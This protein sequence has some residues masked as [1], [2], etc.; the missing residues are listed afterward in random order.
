[1]AGFIDEFLESYGP[2]VTKQMSSNFNVDQATVQKLIPQLAPLI[3]AGLK[4]Q[5]DTRGGDERVDHIL[6]K[7][8]D[9]SVLNN[10]KD[11]VSSKARAKDVDPNLG[12]LLGDAGGV[13]AAQALAKKMNIDPSTIMKMIPALAP[14]LLGALTKKRDTGGK[15]ISGVGAL[16]DA[17]GDGSILDDVAG[18]LLKSGSST[19][20]GSG[21]LLGSIIGGITR[22]K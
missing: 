15:G 14:L 16:L 2:E 7:Y 12:G 19:R 1:M 21:G 22:R 4:K 20:S 10:I 3:L 18:F 9:S 11:L 5:K 8:G 6:N 17:D 13:Q